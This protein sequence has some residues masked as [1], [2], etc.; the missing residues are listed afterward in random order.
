MYGS[1][2]LNWKNDSLYLFSKGKPLV[3]IVP[4]RQYPKMWRVR[5]PDGH[6][7]DMANRARAK[8]AALSIALGILN[9]SKRIAVGRTDLEV[10]KRA[11][12][13]LK[14]AGGSVTLEELKKQL[15]DRSPGNG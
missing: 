1:Q 10:A 15:D 6:T 5:L 8:D 14:A 9:G 4:D 2:E 13:E 7:T 11:L 3:T 12:L